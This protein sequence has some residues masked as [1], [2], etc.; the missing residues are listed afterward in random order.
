MGLEQIAR[1]GVVRDE[2]SL[3]DFL[4]RQALPSL[5]NLELPLLRRAYD[6]AAARDTA[7][8]CRLDREID[9]WKVCKG[10][11]EASIQL[12][13]R[14]LAVL[15]RIFPDEFV[16]AFENERRTRATPGHHLSVYGLQMALGCVPLQAAL[17]AWLYQT[18]AGACSAALKLIRIGQEGCQR[19][20]G[21]CLRD[22]SETVQRSLAVESP[23][24]F[25]PLVE[26]AAMRH[27]RAFER[28]FIS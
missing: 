3:L 16:R 24:W 2:A 21:E 18:L 22:A 28:L 5:E 7:G 8:L 6:A 26:I 4:K 15:L 25:N 12:G 10:L 13:T 9:A 19:V 17:S 14:R 23:G 11:R 27:E 1:A 20:L